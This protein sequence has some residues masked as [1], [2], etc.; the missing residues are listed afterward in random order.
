MEY[1]MVVNKIRW[2]PNIRIGAAEGILKG[3][4]YL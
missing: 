4:I 3:N 1:L 2:N